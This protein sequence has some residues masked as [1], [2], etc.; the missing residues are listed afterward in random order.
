[1]KINGL[2]KQFQIAGIEINYNNSE[3]GQ[4]L[5]I[6]LFNG[7]LQPKQDSYAI[8]FRVPYEKTGSNL[9]REM[10]YFRVQS[11]T[12]I[13]GNFEQGQLQSNVTMNTNTCLSATFS[14]S[15]IFEGKEIVISEGII[16]HIYIYP[17]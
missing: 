14:G 4:T 3:S 16:N 9:I 7:I 15:A 1:M 10:R 2:E 13:T 6:D 5:I 11:P 17:F 8:K 12:S